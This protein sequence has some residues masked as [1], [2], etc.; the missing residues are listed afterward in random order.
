MINK[1]FWKN[2]RDFTIL[3]IS[4][5]FFQILN[6]IYSCYKYQFLSVSSLNGRDKEGLNKGVNRNFKIG[7]LKKIIIS[8]NHALECLSKRF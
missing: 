8:H 6:P 4:K 5:F 2:I 1:K 3:N 7:H